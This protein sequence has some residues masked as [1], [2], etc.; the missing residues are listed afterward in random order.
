MEEE[1]KG[2]KKKKK[3]IH[4]CVWVCVCV[5]GGGGGEGGGLPH[6]LTIPKLSG[7]YM[8]NLNFSQPE[9]PLSENMFSGKKK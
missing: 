2:R 1:N 5:G 4:I 6:T 9:V 3:C 8:E 7:F